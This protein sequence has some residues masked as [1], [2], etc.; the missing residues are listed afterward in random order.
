MLGIKGELVSAKQKVL[1]VFRLIRGTGKEGSSV[2]SP[3]VF[4]VVSYESVNSLT[5]YSLEAE[6][7]KAKALAHLRMWDRRIWKIWIENP[8]NSLFLLNNVRG[9][10]LYPKFDP[11]LVRVFS[12][13]CPTLFIRTKRWFI[14]WER[15]Y[16]YRSTKMWG[17]CKDWR[18]GLSRALRS[19]V[20]L[21]WMRGTIS[22][23]LPLSFLSLGALDHKRKLL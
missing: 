12:I 15:A 4:S 17:W 7:K 21:C 5:N 10:W 23:L 22:F 19:G 16:P 3:A 6:M 2:S 8:L 1:R 18:N 14:E 9:T 20:P 11:T 13:V